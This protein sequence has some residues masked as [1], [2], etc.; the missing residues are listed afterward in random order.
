M[1]QRESAGASPGH[2]ALFPTHSV[3]P[4]A[5]LETRTLCLGTSLWLQG[6]CFGCGPSFVIGLASAASAPAQGQGCQCQL[7]PSPPRLQMA[8][9]ASGSSPSDG[10][11]LPLVLLNH[12]YS[13]TFSRRYSVTT[14]S[15]AHP[16]TLLAFPIPELGSR[17]Y[18]IS[19]I[20]LSY[21]PQTKVVK[22]SKCIPMHS[23]NAIFYQTEGDFNSCPI[24]IH[25]ASPSPAILGVARVWL[26]AFVLH[27]SAI[28][29]DGFCRLKIETFLLAAA[30]VSLGNH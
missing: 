13:I 7:L 22:S 11:L 24:S 23:H 30:D 29:W 18:S 5:L 14:R 21:K 17:R 12:L 16:A 1:P 19:N 4:Q 10:P 9:P 3:T 15:L 6:M 8:P 28:S 27:Q 26:I 2:G 20:V 25:G